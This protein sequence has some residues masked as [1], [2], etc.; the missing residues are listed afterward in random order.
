MKDSQG[1]YYL[2]T[3]T[4]EKILIKLRRLMENE[5]DQTFIGKMG[6]IIKKRSGSTPTGTGQ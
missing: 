2:T 3:E 5:K 1:L 4:D 6:D